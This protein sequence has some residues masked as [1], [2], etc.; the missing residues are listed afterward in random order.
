MNLAQGKGEMNDTHM[1]ENRNLKE[2]TTVSNAILNMIV[3]TDITIAKSR[4]TWMS[5]V[6]SGQE[7]D[8]FKRRAVSDINLAYL[9]LV[10]DRDH[11]RF[12]AVHMMMTTISR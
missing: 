1:N 11:R 6:V 8:P 4:L 10:L 9:D 5:L 3:M 2:K 12:A 7:V